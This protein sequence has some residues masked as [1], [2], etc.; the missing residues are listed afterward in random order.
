MNQKLALAFCNVTEHIAIAAYVCVEK[1][2]EKAADNSLSVLA[3]TIK[4]VFFTCLWI[5]IWIK[6]LLVLILSN[7]LLILVTILRGKI[8]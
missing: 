5:F 7:E 1:D 6:L 4:E 3:L 8:L 2:N